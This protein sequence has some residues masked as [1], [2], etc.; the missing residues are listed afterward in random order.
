MARAGCPTSIFHGL[1]VEL[2]HKAARRAVAQVEDAMK[3]VRHCPES[4]VCAQAVKDR[5]WGESASLYVYWD[6]IL[7]EGR[8][9]E[10]ARTVQA[11][12]DTL[13]RLAQLT[14]RE[15]AWHR[16]RFTIDLRPDGTFDFAPDPDK[17][18]AAAQHAGF[19]A[20]LSDT[21]LISAEVLG[22]QSET[23]TVRKSKLPGVIDADL[24]VG[25]PGGTAGVG[26]SWRSS[27]AY[28]AR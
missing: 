21:A 12:A 26:I 14:K 10:F 15:A 23:Q 2:R 27:Y 17:I 5:F 8:R 20:I 7:A 18:D 19:F 16:G 1:D 25:G 4:G 13:A 22:I 24:L 28:F 3:S 6:T 11:E 9:A